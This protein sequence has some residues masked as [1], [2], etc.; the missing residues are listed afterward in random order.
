MTDSLPFALGAMSFGNRIDEGTSFTLLDR[1]VDAGGVWIDT[2]DCYAF[3]ESPTGHGGTSEE[4]LGRWL[5]ARP[6][7][8][9]RVKLSTK[10]GAEPGT[11][12]DMAPTG[13]R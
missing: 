10:F 6:G 2:A 9:D 8:R 1:F 13:A 12:G 11:A 4:L 3:W 7:M 5:A